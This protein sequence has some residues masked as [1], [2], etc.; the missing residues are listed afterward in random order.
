MARL[1]TISWPRMMARLQW[2]SVFAAVLAGG[3]VLIVFQAWFWEFHPGNAWGLGYGIAGAVLLGGAM[4]Y[5]IRRRA[6]GRGPATAQGWLQFH[7]Y[8]GV[9]F[10]LLILMHSGFRLPTG[11]LAWMMWLLSIWIVVSGVAGRLIQKWIPQLLTS[12]LTTEVHYDRIGELIVEI[13]ER[14]VDLAQASEGPVKQ[15]YWENLAGLLVEPR[16]R[17]IYFIDI[18]GGIQSQVRQF[19]YLRNFLGGEERARLDQLEELAVTKL[20]LDAHYTLQRALRWWLYAHV[21]FS[22]VLVIL[23]GFHIFT[24]LYY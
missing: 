2:S 9:L 17:W 10:L 19:E 16:T 23:V 20:E 22:V 7:L 5:S 6:P 4:A 24:V 3:V 1:Y 12:G 14:A 13:D 18:T 15:F 8:G 21:P 11:G